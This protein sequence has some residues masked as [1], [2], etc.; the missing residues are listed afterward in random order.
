M[1]YKNT[2]GMSSPIKKLWQRIRIIA[3]GYVEWEADDGTVDSETL[4]WRSRWAIFGIH[5]YKWGWVRKYGEL[6][7]GCTINP[8][9]RRRVL[10]SIDCKVHS[11]WGDDGPA[12]VIALP[13]PVSIG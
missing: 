4:S 1:G 12:S 2:W 9:T 6:P 7:C 3:T 8:I 10:T 13:V 5:S 11:G